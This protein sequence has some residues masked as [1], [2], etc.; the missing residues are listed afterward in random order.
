MNRFLLTD[1][2]IEHIEDRTPMIGNAKASH[3]H[4]LIYTLRKLQE[5]LKQL[6]EVDDTRTD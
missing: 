4:D 3:V 6:E 5:Q 1:E 2:D